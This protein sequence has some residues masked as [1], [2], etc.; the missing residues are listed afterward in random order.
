MGQSRR[1]WYLR[2]TRRGKGQIRG[3]RQADFLA[4]KSVKFSKKRVFTEKFTKK[5]TANRG[6]DGLMIL[7][8]FSELSELLRIMGTATEV[9][10]IITNWTCVFFG[11]G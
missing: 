11:A 3:I 5:M 2:K 9:V 1:S 8:L 6:S 7:K 4:I 10:V